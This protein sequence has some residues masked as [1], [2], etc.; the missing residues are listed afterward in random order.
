M[1][2]KRGRGEEKD[3]ACEKTLNK[4]ATTH[5]NPF[6]LLQ[7]KNEYDRYHIKTSL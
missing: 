2:E 5:L 7:T 1:K 6:S 3:S 4:S